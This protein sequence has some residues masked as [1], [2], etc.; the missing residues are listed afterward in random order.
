MY[1]WY[2]MKVKLI[3]VFTDSLYKPSFNYFLK[4]KFLMK[5]SDTLNIF[6]FP[7]DDEKIYRVN[8]A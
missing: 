4:L 7:D 3:K 1:Q 8:R 5:T 2:Y 6:R